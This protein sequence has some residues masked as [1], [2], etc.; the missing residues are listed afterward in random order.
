MVN[1]AESYQGAKVI[2]VLFLSLYRG[3]LARLVAIFSGL[4]IKVHS[5]EAFQ[6]QENFRLGLT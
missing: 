1:R 3:L 2:A 4:R 5:I 6:R